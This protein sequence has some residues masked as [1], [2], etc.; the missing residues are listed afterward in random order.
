MITKINIDCDG[1]VNGRG[2]PTRVRMDVIFYQPTEEEI[3]VMKKL[4]TSCLTRCRRTV[5]E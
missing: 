4:S 3:E 1:A 2:E 5:D